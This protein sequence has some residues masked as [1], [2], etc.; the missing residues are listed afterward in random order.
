MG[1]FPFS[2]CGGR[3]MPNFMVHF[4]SLL[5][6]WMM[7]S[8]KFI[9]KC[10]YNS[11]WKA[12]LISIY[13]KLLFKIHKNFQNKILDDKEININSNDHYSCCLQIYY[14]DLK[15]QNI[16]VFM[17]WLVTFHDW[18]LFD[19]LQTFCCLTLLLKPWLIYY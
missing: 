17:Y 4:T 11:L 10:N 2:A 8:L 16:P 12:T 3:K 14:D 18:R 19:S 5:N 7:R 9:L 6:K 1:H 15:N 13:I